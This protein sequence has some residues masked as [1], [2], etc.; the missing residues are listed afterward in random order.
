MNISIGNKFLVKTKLFDK[1]KTNYFSAELIKPINNFSKRILGIS[2][3]RENKIFINPTDSFFDYPINLINNQNTNFEENQIIELEIPI[4]NKNNDLLLSNIKKT[5]GNIDR[6]DLF[7]YLSIKE[8]GLPEKFPDSVMNEINNLKRKKSL[9]EIDLTNIPF[10]TIDPV[11]AKDRDDAI[12]ANFPKSL[13][14]D[15][16]FCELWVAIADVSSFFE[17]QTNIDNEALSRGNSTYLQDTVIP[18]LPEELSNKLCSL[19]ENVIRYAV[20]LKVNFDKNG[21]KLEH[22]FFKSKIRV[23]YNLNYEEVEELINKERKGKHSISIIIK[24]LNK[25][26]KFLKNKTKNS[27]NIKISEPKIETNILNKSLNLVSNKSLNSHKL[28]ENFMIIANICVGETLSK[29]NFPVIYRHHE[30]PTIYNLNKLNRTLKMIGISSSEKK[31]EP[32]HF[33]SMLNE[34]TD[35]DLKNLISIIILQNMSQAYYSKDYSGHYGLSLKKYVH[36]TSPIRRYADLLVHRQLHLYLGWDLDEIE[37]IN[38]LRYNQ[39]SAHI[40][41]TERKS[42]KAEKQTHSRYLANYMKHFLNDNFTA[43][44]YNILNNKVFFFLVENHIQGSCIYK[45]FQ[46]D[47]RKKFKRKKEVKKLNF[48]LSIGDLISVKLISANDFNGNLV[49]EFQHLLKKFKIKNE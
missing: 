44:I 17:I 13:N 47:K 36:F 12:F 15:K 3:F 43:V 48:S 39:I 14:N 40:S 33:N 16:V 9:H 7:S 24:N 28:V 18:M 21:N 10:I 8:F 19:D 31:N 32:I 26:Y 30:K 49:F 35:K 25:A 37:R 46:H 41:S 34:N 42:I 29:S 11:T 45:Q 6:S 20:T 27:L 5:Y 2:N 38:L 1:T 22:K 4:K 23:K